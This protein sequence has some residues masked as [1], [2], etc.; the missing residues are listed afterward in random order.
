MW[1]FC[2]RPNL[3]CEGLFWASVVEQDNTLIVTGGLCEGVRQAYV[4]NLDT[5]GSWVSWQEGAQAEHCPSR[6]CVFYTWQS[7]VCGMWAGWRWQI[8]LQCWGEWPYLQSAILEKGQ[9][10][11]P[12]EGKHHNI[13][14]CCHQLLQKHKQCLT[15][16]VTKYC[17]DYCCCL[18]WCVLF[19]L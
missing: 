14:L 5:K 8:P 18:C 17:N 2:P 7:S 6:P 10:E 9:R 15:S 3:P 12:T 19:V 13:H 1:A 16:E 4:W 11:L